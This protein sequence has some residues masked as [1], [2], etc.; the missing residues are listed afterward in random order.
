MVIRVDDDLQSL[1]ELLWVREAWQLHP[2]GDDLPPALIDTPIA[3]APAM[4]MSAPTSEW[5]AVWPRV[6]EEVLEHAG[7]TPR[8][9]IFELLQATPNGSPDRASLL[10]ELVGPSWREEVGGEAFTDEAEQWMQAQFE[11]RVR[12]SSAGLEAQPE[13]LSLEALIQA[14]KCGLTTVVQIPCRGA[15]TRRIGPHA[16][17]V[18]AGTRADPERYAEALRMFC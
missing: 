10:R 1:L 6:W 5:E 15:F 12:P 16:I 8:P 9:D 18:T 14:W 17:L 2:V 3:V 7:T 11:Q 4:R 13:R